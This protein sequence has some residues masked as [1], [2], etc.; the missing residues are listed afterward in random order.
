[1]I[2]KRDYGGLGNK[3]HADINRSMHSIDERIAA[4]STYTPATP[5]DWADPPP[6]TIAEALDRLAAAFAG[7][8][9]PVP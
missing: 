7:E 9:S 6:S 5:G 2:P 8:H 3:L 1:M 4:T